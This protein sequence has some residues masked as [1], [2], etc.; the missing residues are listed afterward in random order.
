MRRRGEA[1]VTTR[2]SGEIVN[3]HSNSARRVDIM[4]TSSVRL[5]APPPKITADFYLI[6]GSGSMAGGDWQRYV[7]SISYHRPTNSRVFVST[8]SCVR[9]GKNLNS[10]DPFGGTEIWYSYWTIL[11]HMS[12]GDSLVIISDFDST[13]PLLPHEDRIIR[14]KVSETGVTVRTI[15]P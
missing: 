10:L 7:R 6:D 1:N 15:R 5:M 3:G 12:Q 11:D 14:Q 13:F 8:T 9:R 4:A 2:W